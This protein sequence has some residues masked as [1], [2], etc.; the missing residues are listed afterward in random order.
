MVT[1]G[2]ARHFMAVLTLTIIS[3][4]AGCGGGSSSSSTS[5]NN[6]PPVLKAITVS[7]WAS[8]NLN[9]GDTRQF[10][11]TGSYSD[12][13]SKDVTASVAWS[14]SNT[15]VATVNSS[16]MVTAA[17]G[18][19]ANISAT[20]S[21]MS[22][23]GSV[24]VNP[25]L[26]SVAV[27]STGTTVSPNATL[28]LTAT[29]TY[30]DSST[31]VVT[32]QATW[33]SSDTTVASVDSNGLVT[34][35]A[36]GSVQITATFGGKSGS[37]TLTVQTTLTS[38]TVLPANPTLQLNTTQ[39]L[40][41][42]A[43]YSDGSQAD[44]TNQ[45]QWSTGDTTIA[46]VDATGLATA[47][48]TGSTSV[49][50]TLNGTSGSTTL[51]VNPPQLSS[52][53]LDQDGETIP[54]GLPQQLTATGVFTDGSTAE[55]TGVSFTSSDTTI[56]S[57][58]A[59]G[60]ASTLATGSVTITATVGSVSGTGTLTVGPQTL[61]SIAVTP[62]NASI[63]VSLTE[64]FTVTGTFTDS[65]TQVL[66]SGVIWSSSDTTAA[67]VDQNGLAT[68]V[69]VGSSTI[70]AT[71]GALT[72]S[73]SLDVTAAKLVSIAVTP[74]TASVPVGV[75]QQFTATGT[76]DDTTTQDLTS[77]VTWMSSNGSVATVNAYGDAIGS[78]TGTVTITAST[79]GVSGT[80]TLTIDNATI[81]TLTITP[82]NPSAKKGTWVQFT[83]TATFSDGSTANVTN[84]VAWS[85]SK[86]Q[87]AHIN[88]A[89]RARAHKTGSATIRAAFHGQ[90][91]TTTFTVTN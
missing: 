54:L 65:S 72:S 17:G 15:A 67:T 91:A 73:G 4:L 24:T 9:V 69:G 79:T 6:T 56:I 49:T 74:N 34:G 22:A 35:V 11:A 7:A 23:N 42:S 80:A 43:Q 31:G 26:T 38:V 27:S 53:I 84:Q 45:A 10:A 16:G 19:S 36:N 29:A 40:S 3:L 58:D 63:P 41:A 8:G 13:S 76:Y 70:T 78:T 37:E 88:G 47:V 33:S 83:A 44:V 18:G 51:T 85:S 20:L 50:A 48:A 77:V 81:T 62:T 12:G 86:P 32:S 46:S 60:L 87:I 90:T 66:T 52:I 28:Q 75:D 55:L 30:S 68:G 14:S 2:Y 57:V 64:Q 1:K 61:V 5:Q 21:G 82:V 39:Q 71:V 89:G 25:A 59:N